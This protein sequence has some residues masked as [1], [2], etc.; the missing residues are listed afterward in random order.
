MT[1][2]NQLRSLVKRSP[3]VE[4]LARSAWSG[5]HRVLRPRRLQRYLNETDGVRLM[6][7]SGATGR[8]GWL[9][10]DLTPMRSDALFLDASK[11]F[12]FET[13]SVDRIYSEHMIEHVDFAAGQAMLREC[14]RVLKPGGRFRIATPD[15]DIFVGLVNGPLGDDARRYVSTSNR[16]NGGVPENEVNDPIYA[17]NRMFSGHGHRFLYSEKLVQQCLSGLGFEN[18]TRFNVG[19]SADPEFNDIEDH[20]NRIDDQSNRFQT[21]VVE[22]EKPA[23]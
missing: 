15:F 12:P 11:P 22:A 18:V 1:V 10:T 8:P 16:R 7:G 21:L 4:Q 19:E 13:D 2:T 9:A 6:I 3:V 14:F 20:G 23:R 17:V 5:S